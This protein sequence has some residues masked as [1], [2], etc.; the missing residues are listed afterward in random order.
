ME[1]SSRQLIRFLYGGPR[2]VIKA[3]LTS[4]TALKYDKGFFYT[5]DIKRNFNLDTLVNQLKTFLCAKYNTLTRNT[6]K[7][8]TM[9]IL[10]YTFLVREK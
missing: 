8:R 1:R 4:N 7:I 5:V 9:I 3:A 2:G 10:F 6:T